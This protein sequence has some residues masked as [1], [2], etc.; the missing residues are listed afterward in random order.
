MKKQLLSWAQNPTYNNKWDRLALT[1]QGTLV[2][3]WVWKDES[4]KFNA[5]VFNTLE[6]EALITKRNFDTAQSA[7]EF[8]DQELKRQG[9]SS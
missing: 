7:K 8:A 9:Y 2:A 6:G 3:A 4:E 1:K 5:S